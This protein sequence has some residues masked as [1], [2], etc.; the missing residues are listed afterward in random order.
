MDWVATWLSVHVSRLGTFRRVVMPLSVRG[1]VTGI[2]LSFAH[3]LGEFGD[4]LMVGGNLPGV[5][6]TVS[7]KATSVHLIPR[8]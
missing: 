3:T 2:V 4:V 6:R 7:I 5:T 1:F 8:G